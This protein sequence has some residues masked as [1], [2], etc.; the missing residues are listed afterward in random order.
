MDKLSF[1]A[2]TTGLQSVVVEVEWQQDSA[3]ITIAAK[4]S[5]LSL[6]VHCPSL[7]V[8]AELARWGLM[9]PASPQTEDCPAITMLEI[10]LVSSHDHRQLQPAI[11][12]AWLLGRPQA[13][14][15]FKSREITT[16]PATT[17]SAEWLYEHHNLHS[18]T[19]GRS[20]AV[21]DLLIFREATGIEHWFVC[22]GSGWL[23]LQREVR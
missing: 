19:L 12:Q 9:L 4:N 23:H 15:H 17:A 13:H 16:L 6:E 11:T 14:H 18:N 1:T 5:G 20:L 3:T 8:S 7:L 2:T 21:G 22:Q 10:W